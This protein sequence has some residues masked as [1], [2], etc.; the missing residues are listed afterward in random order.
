[1]NIDT[2][3][4]IML[5]L[6]YD[7]VIAMCSTYQLSHQACNDNFWKKKIELDY[8]IVTNNNF[9][10]NYK[11]LYAIE[12]LVKQLFKVLEIL[13][14][15]YILI[16]MRLPVENGST[17]PGHD[18]FYGLI[19]EIYFIDDSNN[20]FEITYLSNDEDVEE[21]VIYIND[22]MILL[23][24]LIYYHPNIII[25][26]GMNEYPILYVDLIKWETTLWQDKRQQ[27]LKLWQDIM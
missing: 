16:T 24:G 1:M 20:Y 21:S 13:G 7:D 14:H 22:L 9:K 23:I 26:E 5:N 15:K 3:Q 8:K 18:N 11:K 27:L 2:L 25:T 6:S 17:T 4:E 10:N 12:I 19:N